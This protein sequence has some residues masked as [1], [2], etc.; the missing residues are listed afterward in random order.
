MTIDNNLENK[1]RNV[2]YT[3]NPKSDEEVYINYVI[4][5]HC[6][7]GDSNEIKF[8]AQCKSCCILLIIIF[9]E[10]LIVRVNIN[11]VMSNMKYF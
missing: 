4:I 7:D 5:K 8:L 10:I 2:N 11:N 1:N 9:R 6:N 3:N